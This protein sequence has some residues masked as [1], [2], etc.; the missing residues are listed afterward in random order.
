M[1][2]HPIDVP[3]KCFTIE[4]FCMAHRLGRSTYYRL[5]EEG[6]GPE[7]CRLHGKIVITKEAAARW[8]TARD[9]EARHSHENERMQIGRFDAV[10]ETTIE[11]KVHDRRLFGQARFSPRFD[12]D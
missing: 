5:R 4:E 9:A 1:A 11:G 6:R 7:E 10:V 3:T 12:R 2:R 8:R